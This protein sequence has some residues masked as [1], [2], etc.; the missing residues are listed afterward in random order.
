MK[1]L[2]VAAAGAALVVVTALSGCSSSSS[3]SGSGSGTLTIFDHDSLKSPQG[4]QLI[5]EYEKSH[6]HTKVRLIHVPSSGPDP[7]INAQMAGGTGS[8]IMTLDT[9]Q[10]PWKDLG[11]NWWMDLTADA[12]APDPYVK[13]NKK[14]LDLLTPGAQASLPFKD[15]KIY[16]LSTTG[17]DVGF[18]YNK[19]IFSKLGLNPP[20]TW[21]EM[22]TD[23]KK[24][25]AAGYTP[26]EFELGDHQYADQAPAFLT[27]L[28]GTVMHDSIQKMD[29]NHDGTVD[30]QEMVE[31]I[32]N[33]SYSAKNADY[34]ESWK[35][36]KSLAPYFQ[37]SPSSAKGSQQGLSGFQSGKVAT[38]F[39]GSFNSPSI[40]SKAFTWDAFPMP[41]IDT[42]ASTFGTDDTTY[43]T[44]AFGAC[45]GYPWSIPVTT[46]TKGNLKAAKDFI[47][48]MSTPKN[49]QTFADQSGV[50]NME[51]GAKTPANLQAF[52]QAASHVSAVASAELSLQPDFITKRATLT[53]EYV[54]GAMTL[55]SAMQQM[56][57][58][59]DAA[60]TAATKTYSLK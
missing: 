37:F 19:N 7:I 18:F 13:G 6:P 5:A 27:I 43:P 55:Q 29:T 1:R 3:S 32:K 22:V 21:T 4:Q 58:A 41:R 28:E 50:L 46:K 59:M 36:L 30:V 26:L 56:Q 15:G 47:Y 57:Q 40:T 31:G 2:S 12:N 60:A 34:Q 48:W 8:D 35:L 9:N 44:G 42:A 25:K 53:E 14:W 51:K 16:S 33:G 39:E 54:T 23:F 24:I 38:W 17:F 45:C 10:Q 11:K 49:A 20:Q 52:A